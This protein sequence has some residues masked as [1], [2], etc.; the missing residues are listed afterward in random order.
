MADMAMERPRGFR[1]AFD[2]EA[3]NQPGALPEVR[4]LAGDEVIHRTPNVDIAVWEAIQA[5]LDGI[6][7]GHAG[8][9]D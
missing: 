7:Q 9:D 5:E 1:E 4:E 3:L 6:P 2:K 8:S